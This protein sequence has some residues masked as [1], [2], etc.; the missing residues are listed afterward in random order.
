[1]DQSTADITSIINGQ[2]GDLLRGGEIVP[3]VV[4]SSS[5]TPILEEI[6]L[7][8]TSLEDSNQVLNFNH[9]DLVSYGGNQDREGL[10]ETT[11]DGNFLELTGNLW[12]AVNY[13]YNI[14]PDTVMEFDFQSTVEGEIHGIGF[15]IDTAATA[16]QQFQLHGTQRSRM[17]R[18]FANYDEVTGGL[19]HYRIPVGRYYTGE[20]NYLAFRN[21]HDVKNPT[22]MSR[23]GNIRVYE[24]PQL[25][26]VTTI[27]NETEIIQEYPL[28]SYGGNQDRKG[29]YETTAD[30]NFLS[31]TGNLWKAVNYKY[32]ITPDTVM[33]FDFQ[34]TVEGEIHGIGF[35][36][37]TSATAKQQFQLHGT[38]LSRMAQDFA[39]LYEVPGS[40]KHY[41]IPVGE[42]FTGEINYLT[43]RND[44]DVKNP[45][46]MSRFG[47][48]RIYERGNISVSVTLT[49]D[50][51][52]DTTDRITSEPHD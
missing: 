50:T 37:D 16:K 38:Q 1:M 9:Y 51:G 43:F 24:D 30:G 27:E 18:D 47:N 35:D 32:N 46:G 2:E 11:A 19:Q 34:S 36:F 7:Q 17:N 15:D 26:R 10:Y 49:N 5:Q 6:S 23:F 40:W 39:G 31:L 8:K 13:K 12:K 22:G 4:S 21:D 48:M 33:E 28:T 44:H 29:L 3:P 45:T 42:Y 25:L 14:T 20:V 52:S 41:R